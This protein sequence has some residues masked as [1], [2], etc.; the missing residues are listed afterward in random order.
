MEKAVVAKARLGHCLPPWEWRTARCGLQRH[1]AREAL[2][3]PVPKPSWPAAGTQRN[4][5]PGQSSP[6]P[7]KLDGVPL[8]PVVCFPF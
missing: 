6:P 7:S 3:D 5:G 1:Q 2:P 4:R 8:L